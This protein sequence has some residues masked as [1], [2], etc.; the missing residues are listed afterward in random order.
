MIFMSVYGKISA[1]SPSQDEVDDYLDLQNGLINRKRDSNFCKHGDEGMCDY[2]S[3]IEPF[4]EKYLEDNKIKHMSLH[5]YI[6][7]LYSEIKNPQMKE[8]PILDEPDY[9]VKRNCPSHAPYP[10]G[11]CTKCQPSAI[12]L[13]RQKF[14]IVDHI[15]F[16]HS[17]I[18][19]NFIGYWRSTG[20]QRFGYLYGKYVPYDEV[21]LGIKA[22]VHAIYEPPQD[23]SVDGFELLAD[24]LLPAVDRMSEILGLQ[25]VGMIYSDLTDDGTNT[26]KVLNKRNTDTFFVSGLETMFMAQ[27]Q[28]HNKSRCKHSSSGKFGSKFVTVIATGD[29]NGGIAL[30]EFQ[31]SNAC[32][33]MTDAGIIEASTDPSLVLVSECTNTK[34]VPEVFYKYKNEYNVQVQQAANP[35]FPVEYLLVRL[36]HGFPSNPSL[37]FS[38]VASFPTLNRPDMKKPALTDLKKYL[39]TDLE[40]FAKFANFEFLCYLLELSMISNVFES[41]FRMILCVC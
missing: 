37:L 10:D 13:Q 4:D 27:M 19:E 26:G 24:P 20:Y 30:T 18:V 33:A 14:R 16:Q 11:L 36:T 25:K 38:G 21:P 22:E 23:C 7:S 1:V 9:T 3:P 35:T 6:K 15:E 12:V 5:S 8:L 39:E 31:A 28:L 40:L 29:E 34:Y 32:M 17:Y 2:C 41:K